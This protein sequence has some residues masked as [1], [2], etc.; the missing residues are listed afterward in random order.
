MH[1]FDVNTFLPI[2]LL[3][4]SMRE[5]HHQG[6]SLHAKVTK[7]IKSDVWVTVHRNSVWIRKTN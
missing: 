1:T 7:P 3:R 5:H 4:V 2:T 6:V